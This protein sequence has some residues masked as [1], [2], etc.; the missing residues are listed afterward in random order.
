MPKL[1]A[2]YNTKSRSRKGKIQVLVEWDNKTRGASHWVPLSACVP[3][4]QGGTLQGGCPILVSYGKGQENQ[5]SG[6]LFYRNK[7]VG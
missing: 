1:T 5:W 2:P 7:S 6:H 4:I 3:V